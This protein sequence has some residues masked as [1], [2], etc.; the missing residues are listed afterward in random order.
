MSEPKLKILHVC[1]R[2]NF[3]GLESYALQM[4]LGQRGLGHSVEMIV[5]A[6]S[7]LATRAV[8]AGVKTLTLNHGALAKIS[9]MK[10][11]TK[12]L[13]SSDRP[14]IIHLHSTQDLDLTMTPLAL[15]RLGT[16]SRAVSQAISKTKARTR[17]ILQTHIWISHSKRDP[18]HAALYSLVDEM[19]CSSEPARQT[20]EKYI[21]IP[22]EKIR[23]IRYGREI[24]QLEKGFLTREAAR[25]FLKLPSEATVVGTVARIDAGKGV[26]ELLDASVSLM[27]TEPSLHLVWIGPPT[28]DD[29]KAVLL[30]EQILNEVHS[31]PD[32]IR[33]RVHFPGAVADSYKYLRAFD[34]FALPTYNEC[35]SLALLEAQL[36]SLP[37]LTSSSGGS[38][39][40]VRENQTGW[41]FEPRSTDACSE[42]LK[43]A[44]GDRAKWPAF[45]RAAHNQVTEFYDFQKVLPTT[46]AAYLDALK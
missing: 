10:A 1:P 13:T 36:A 2:P 3:S 9:F 28:S 31:L 38:P 18:L 12:K 41:L 27:K 24:A 14:D 42:A 11:L 4:A 21:P 32:G 17:V 7:P 43:R 15:A 19:W 16:A 23:V 30:S 33:E 34:L 39:Q 45:G 8:E 29:P 44:L 5:L 20:L 35:F 37:C 6:D 25:E 26:R 22:A 46:I 40:I